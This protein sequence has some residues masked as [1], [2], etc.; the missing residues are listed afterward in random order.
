MIGIKNAHSKKYNFK[1][2]LFSSSHWIVGYPEM[3]LAACIEGQ[4]TSYQGILQLNEFIG[5]KLYRKDL[6]YI[7]MLNHVP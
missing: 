1:N 7:Q 2:I 5:V 4:L 6:K 3:E